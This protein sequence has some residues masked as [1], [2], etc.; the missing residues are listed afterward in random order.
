MFTLGPRSRTPQAPNYVNTSKKLH[1]TTQQHIFPQTRITTTRMTSTAPLQPLV[2][3]SDSDSEPEPP[4]KLQKRSVDSGL[5][6]LP[7]RFHD[8]YAVPPRMAKDDDPALHGGR[9]RAIPHVQGNWPTHVFVECMCYHHR[10]TAP[11]EL[12]D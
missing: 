11:R 2:D 1:A 9:K 7:S 10:A 12:R 3:Y 5:P 8:L 6:P 4:A